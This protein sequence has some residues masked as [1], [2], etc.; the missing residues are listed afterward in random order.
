M[1]TS[2]T[3][4]ASIGGLKRR[5]SRNETIAASAAIERTGPSVCKATM[6][7]KYRGDQIAEEVESVCDGASKAA[8]ERKR[9][10]RKDSG[11][12]DIIQQHASHRPMPRAPR[13]LK[14]SRL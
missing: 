10:R 1:G 2:S 4:A 13:M 12:P 8:C 14:T 7:K 11:L 6:P 9:A 5:C 3:S